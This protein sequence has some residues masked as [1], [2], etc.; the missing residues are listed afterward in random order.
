M[1]KFAHA[2][3]GQAQQPLPASRHGAKALPKPA[4][5]KRI[6]PC[7]TNRLT[8]GSSLLV[9]LHIRFRCIRRCEGGGSLTAR[10]IGLRYLTRSGGTVRGQPRSHWTRSSHV[11]ASRRRIAGGCVAAAWPRQ[12]INSGRTPSG[13]PRIVATAVR[14]KEVTGPAASPML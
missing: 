7:C 14:L 12:M 13:R 11:G 2:G 6:T 1:T 4:R 5:V 8:M 3:Y 9:T 10:Q